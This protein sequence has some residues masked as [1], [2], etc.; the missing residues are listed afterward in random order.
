MLLN[1]KALNSYVIHNLQIL[2]STFILS[3]TNVNTM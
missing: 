3:V 2:L 1:V